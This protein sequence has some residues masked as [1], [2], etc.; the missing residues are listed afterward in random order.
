MNR[1]SEKKNQGK[2]LKFNFYYSFMN[3]TV[4]FVEA[5]DVLLTLK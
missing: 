3:T 5:C 2:G 4:N 1:F